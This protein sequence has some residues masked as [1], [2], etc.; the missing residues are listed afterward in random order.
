MAVGNVGCVGLLCALC[1]G[2]IAAYVWG[3][4][5]GI[6]VG[7]GAVVLLA[8][9]MI[10]ATNRAKAN[11]ENEAARALSADQDLD[12]INALRAM[13]AANRPAAFDLAKNSAAGDDDQ[14]A[15][16]PVLEFEYA[17]RGG[18]VSQRKVWAWTEEDDRFTG[19]CMDTGAE[20]T[21][22]KA[23]VLRWLAGSEL[24]LNSPD[25]G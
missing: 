19:I 21:F 14:Q 1:A 12:E 4:L 11:A 13:A 17:D 2:V 16:G 8:I 24:H 22:L 15:E 25:L 5:A 10:P 18:N 3:G 9:Y 23:S 7:S 6:L 20:R